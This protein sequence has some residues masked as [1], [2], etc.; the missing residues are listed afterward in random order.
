[1]KIILQFSPM[2]MFLIMLGVGMSV[3]IKNFI[4]VLKSLKVLLIGLFLQIIILPSIGFF[5]VIY[6]SVDSVLKLGIILITCVPSAVTSNYITKLAGGNVAL[7]VCLTA[8][9]ACLSFVSIPFITTIVAPI[10]TDEASIF[11][12][13]NF[14]KMSLTLL[15]ITTIPVLLADVIPR[16]LSQI[17][18]HGQIIQIVIYKYIIVT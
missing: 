11:Q 14:F 8:I 6:L 17:K 18:V 4:K 10:V 5:F 2:I 16:V 15:M 9:T 13:L 12:E 7:S 3:S 1:M